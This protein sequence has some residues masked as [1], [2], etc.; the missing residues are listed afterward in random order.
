MRTYEN[1]LR[2]LRHQICF[3]LG[4]RLELRFRFDV[5]I[6]FRIV[7]LSEEEGVSHI[8]SHNAYFDLL[9]YINV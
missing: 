5:S 3:R 4:F 2:R 7:G 6:Y 9:E 1:M 8:L